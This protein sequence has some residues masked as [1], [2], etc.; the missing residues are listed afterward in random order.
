M[1][2][3]MFTLFM[4]I[5]LF[6]QGY[7]SSSESEFVVGATPYSLVAIVSDQEIDVVPMAWTCGSWSSWATI[8]VY[9]TN[10]GVCAN[11]CPIRA[12]L[13]YRSRTCVDEAGNQFLDEQQMETY[14]GCC[15]GGPGGQCILPRPGPTHDWGNT[16]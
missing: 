11:G 5:T 3:V 13:Q 7:A 9:C 2:L 10:S 6:V 12:N 4:F 16:E 8:A 15:S 14:S 1:R